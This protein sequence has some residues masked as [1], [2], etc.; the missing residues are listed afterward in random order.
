MAEVADAQAKKG[1]SQK[2]KKE[3]YNERK[4]NNRIGKASMNTKPPTAFSQKAN[5]E[6][7]DQ[8]IRR[9]LSSKQIDDV[10]TLD[11]SRHKINELSDKVKF[12]MRMLRKVRT[13]NLYA[14]KLRVVPSEIGTELTPLLLTFRESYLSF[15]GE[16]ISLK[17][18][19][20][21]ENCVTELP[22][23]IGKLIQLE[24]LG[25]LCSLL[26]NLLAHNRQTF[27]TT[28]SLLF[29]TRLATSRLYRSC[30]FDGTSSKSSQLTSQT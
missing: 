15:I 12:Y 28:V 6:S 30:S 23:S 5:K 8:F 4:N 29:L 14:N 19:G 24:V 27:A 20:L 21:N 13:L 2:A 18:L 9:V 22:P 1:F 10:E 25:T 3:Q 11:L 17:Y 7:L 16:M 26:L